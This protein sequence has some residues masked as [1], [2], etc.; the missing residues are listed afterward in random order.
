MNYKNRIKDTGIRQGRVAEL[1]GIRRSLF[2]EY[3]GGRRQFPKKH[4]VK[5]DFV[6]DTLEKTMKSLESLTPKTV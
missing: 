1:L 6:L 2:N 5:L 3:L 4:Q